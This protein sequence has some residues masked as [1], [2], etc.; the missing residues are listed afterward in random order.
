MLF[1]QHIADLFYI[2]EK[3]GLRHVVICP[4]SRNAP[5]IQGFTRNN[6]FT[7]H[8]IVDERSAGYVALGMAR[9]LGEC[10][11]VVTT[12]GT[13]A[14]N[15]YPA[16]AEAWHQKIPLL[17]LTADR[18]PEWPLQ[19]NNQII[20]QHGIFSGNAKTFYNIPFTVHDKALKG[21]YEDLK[22]I[23]G[24]AVE[25]HSGPV[26]INI[27]LE[28]P[29]YEILT[30]TNSKEVTSL[31]FSKKPDRDVELITEKD[32][33][34][35]SDHLIG[36][37]KVLVLAG[38]R[39]YTD[40]EKFLMGSLAARYQ[41]VVVAENIANL[42]SDLFIGNPELI[43]GSMSDKEQGLLAPDLLLSIGGQIVSKKLKLMI[44]S[45]KE[46]KILS[47]ENPPVKLFRELAHRME[48]REENR[49]LHIWKSAASVAA[50]KSREFFNTAPF[51][52]LS[53]T[54]R[55]MEVIP[56]DSVVHL[57][58]SSTIR[59]SQLFPVRGDLRF[60][61]NRGTSGIDGCLSSAVGAAMV[62]DKLHVLI[63]GDLSFIYD[64]NGL[65]NKDFPENLRIIVLNDGGGGIFR[66]IEGPDRMPFFEEFSVTHHPVSI[67]LLVEAFGLKYRISTDIAALEQGLSYIFEKDSG[68]CVIEVETSKSENSAIFRKFFEALK[69][70]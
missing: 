32:Q 36:M 53:A 57:G 47:L 41:V 16:V 26:H 15:L 7:C 20:D 54:G 28:E 58:N 62:S 45:M 29:L 4:G 39:S 50:E 6:S 68:A 49:Y 2:L 51:C 8:S 37:K 55:I 22:T 67:Q 65:W 35:I 13:A 5:L 64:S 66:I 69:N 46:L 48:T 12:S 21:L 10:V 3:S 63:L 61:S 56:G 59:Y 38:M 17:L 24:C 52:I 33:I 27:Q 18:P 11:A 1:N 34:L 60:Y 25:D 31:D 9:E 43:L 14:L 44:N 40:E 42:S 70:Q 19:F 30:E 23:A